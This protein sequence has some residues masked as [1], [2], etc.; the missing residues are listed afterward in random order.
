MAERNP[1]GTEVF[2]QFVS[3]V[4]VPPREI[5]LFSEE[6]VAA[7]CEPGDRVVGIRVAEFVRYVVQLALLTRLDED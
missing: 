4:E 5:V 2:V 3:F 6:V 1:A 7:Y